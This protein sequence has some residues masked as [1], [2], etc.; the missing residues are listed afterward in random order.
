M[1][2]F[3]RPRRV[4]L[5]KFNMDKSIEEVRAEV[6]KSLLITKNEGWEA[7]TVSFTEVRKDRIYGFKKANPDK[8]ASCYVVR[9]NDPSPLHFTQDKIYGDPVTPDDLIYH[10]DESFSRKVSE[11]EIKKG[12]G[13][14]EFIVWA[15]G[16][17][18]IILAVGF[19][20]EISVVGLPFAFG[21]T[22]PALQ[23][24]EAGFNAVP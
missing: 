16:M 6:N 8:L 19:L 11:V 3:D 15:L 21:D 14:Q 17:V 20:F 7:N 5:L 4:T 12:K 24:G 22:P 1:G 23:P 2:L 9:E 13:Q 10:E 18:C